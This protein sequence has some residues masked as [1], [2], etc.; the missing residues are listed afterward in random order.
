MP[1]LPTDDVAV[2]KL[3]RAALVAL[4]AGIAG[5]PHVIDHATYVEGEAQYVAK[6]GYKHPE[7]GKT[8]YRLLEIV[9]GDFKD[10]DIGCDDNPSYQLLYTLNLLVQHADTRGT[11]D[12]AA[13]STD[14]FARFILTLRRKVLSGRYLDSGK[15]LRCEN[16]LPVTSRFGA[17]DELNLRAAHFASFLLAVEVTPSPITI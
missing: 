13:S 4:F 15:Q 16:L 1:Q 9:F 8:E 5:L 2:E 11:S 3:A 17:D 14:D 7:T 12:E 10:L 6:F